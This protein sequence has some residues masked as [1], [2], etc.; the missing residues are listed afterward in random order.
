MNGGGPGLKSSITRQRKTA[1]SRYHTT[2]VPVPAPGFQILTAS[3]SSPYTLEG[4]NTYVL[5]T[6]SLIV[7]DP[8]PEDSEHIARVRAAATTVGQVALI[9]VTHAHPDH[10]GAA[11]QLAALTGAP[12]GRWRA[13]DHPLDDG[14]VLRVDD[15][16]VRALHTPGH[17]PDHLVFHWEDRQT[18]FSGDLILGTGTVVVAPPAGSMEDYL[19]SLERL[20]QLDLAV[21]APGH[22]PVITNPAARIA[23]YVAHRRMREQQVLE[24]LAGGP[25]TPGEIA[26]VIYPDLAPRLHPAAEGTVL[27]HLLKLLAE[28]RV[29][30]EGNRFHIA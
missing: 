5:G 27:A 17:A 4:T 29:T 10:M 3:N 26:A 19:R 1:N 12:V 13:G 7:I 16:R 14:E 25:H 30:R 20:A 6:A 11:R 8:G 2:R 21:I 22:G 15:V 28:G 23:E 24:V 18:L 9:L